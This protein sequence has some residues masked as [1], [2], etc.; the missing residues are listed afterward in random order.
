MSIRNILKRCDKHGQFLPCIDCTIQQGWEEH[1][2]K[3]PIPGKLRDKAVG[4]VETTLHPVVVKQY[5]DGTTIPWTLEVYGWRATL[6]ESIDVQL[7]EPDVV[8]MTH[9]G[10]VLF[11]ERV[12][13]TEIEKKAAALALVT[14]FLTGLIS[15]LAFVTG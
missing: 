11:T 4:M 12:S 10:A 7:R 9:Y 5:H 2:G 1:G 13:G 6:S 8:V 15:K 14:H 3:G